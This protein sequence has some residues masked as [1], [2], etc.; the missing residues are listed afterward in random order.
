M[1]LLA[2]VGFVAAAIYFHRWLAKTETMKIRLRLTRMAS[3]AVPGQTT[4][5][6]FRQHMAERG[7]ALKASDEIMD[8][9]LRGDTSVLQVPA[10]RSLSWQEIPALAVAGFGDDGR[11]T[12]IQFRIEPVS[13]VTYSPSAMTTFCEFA[14][15]ECDS[16]AAWLRAMAA[17]HQPEPTPS[18][19]EGED[20]S[21]DDLK[22]LGLSPGASMEDVQAAYRAA[23]LRFH[24]DRLAGASPPD[25]EA[26][27]RKFQQVTEA[28]RREKAKVSHACSVK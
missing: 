25:V 1:Y 26:A 21:F 16:I 24:P 11:S 10:Q 18:T 6:L 9:F 20:A 3:V 14:A 12:F 19:A 23:C 2:L 8:V 28:Y 5:H 17:K 13:C 22:T 15:S 7:F 4:R 27:S